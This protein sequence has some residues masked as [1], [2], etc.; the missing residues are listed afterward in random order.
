MYTSVEIAKYY[1]FSILSLFVD[2]HFYYHYKKNR[3]VAMSFNRVYL[4]MHAQ[5]QFCLSLCGVPGSR[6]ALGLFEP[7]ERL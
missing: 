6:C 3:K 1:K 5:T 7:S 2:L 4:N